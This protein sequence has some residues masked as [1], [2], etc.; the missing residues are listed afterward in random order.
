MSSA[1]AARL[2]TRPS[3]EKHYPAAQYRARAA[4]LGQAVWRCVFGVDLPLV[5]SGARP[6][7]FEGQHAGHPPVGASPGG[8]VVICKTC[9][10]PQK[11][12]PAGVFE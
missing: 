10:H 3:I 11:R 9:R 12:A 1:P 2:I 8:H 5:P 7:R 6:D 4:A